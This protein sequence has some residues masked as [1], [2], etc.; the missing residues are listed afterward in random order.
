MFGRR[1]REAITAWQR[2]RG[3]RQTGFLNDVQRQALLWEGAKTLARYDA[4]QRMIEEARLRAARVQ[5]Q[6]VVLTN[7]SQAPPP[8][9]V[10][11]PRPWFTIW[12]GHRRY[13]R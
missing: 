5:P 8:P 9:T 3:L 6:P 11:G 10:V 13:H 1:S 12:S 4:E 2:A 7:P